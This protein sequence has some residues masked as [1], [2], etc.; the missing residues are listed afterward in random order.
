MEQRACYRVATHL[1]LDQFDLRLELPDGRTF[2]ARMEDVSARGLMARTHGCVIPPLQ[3]GSRIAL[4][5]SCRKRGISLRL[6]ATV[7]GPQSLPGESCYGLAFDQPEGLESAIPN[8]L[9]SLFN[10]RRTPRTCVKDA[11][12]GFTLEASQASRRAAG[13]LRDVSLSGASVA[14]PLGEDPKF[15]LGERISLSGR[16]PAQQTG[17]P[18]VAYVRRIRQTPDAIVYGIEFDWEHAAAP[19]QRRVVEALVDRSVESAASA[20]QRRIAERRITMRAKASDEAPIEVVL[21]GHGNRRA[22]ATLRDL[23]ATGAG[24]VVRALEDPEFG[25][26]ESMQLSMRLPGG[27]LGV[28]ARVRRGL[29]ID[30]HVCY[31]LEFDLEASKDFQSSQE[32]ILSFLE[33]HL[34]DVQTPPLVEFS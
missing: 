24:V 14:V 17:S 11:E 13:T 32:L 9:F 31:G 29:L 23:S 25:D 8:D 18:L 33:A 27:T 21:V 3:E 19:Y 7:R 5:L 28:I 34:G 4:R 6:Y 30:D 2:P 10:R 1:A 12:R 20:P 15:Q 16:F 26:D 22:S